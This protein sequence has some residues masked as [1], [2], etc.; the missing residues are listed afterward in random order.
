MT[1]A[2]PIVRSSSGLGLD[3]A[4]LGVGGLRRVAEIG[5]GVNV[6]NGNKTNVSAILP[7][8]LKNT[9]I[10]SGILG[11]GR[12]HGCGCNQVRLSGA[13]AQAVA[14]QVAIALQGRP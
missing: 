1:G 3:L 10:L 6:L 11:G 12:S 8:S 13:E 5:G 9:S 4:D 7:I 2:G 14:R